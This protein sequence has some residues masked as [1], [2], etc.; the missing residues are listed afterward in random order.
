M[1]RYNV[2]TKHEG[3]VLVFNTYTLSLMELDELYYE[4]FIS[5]NNDFLNDI[6]KP[7]F[8]DLIE[9]GF[10]IKDDV[11]EISLLRNSYWDNK[12]NNPVLH[13][14]VMTTLD[15]NFRCIYC[16][17]NRQSVEM[18]DN[19]QKSVINFIKNELSSRQYQ[20]VHI[21]WYGGEP[22][23]NMVCI[24]RISSEIIAECK[25]KNILYESS[26]M[27]NGYL[28]SLENCLK[29]KDLHVS[30][31]QITIDGTKEIHDSRRPLE[32]NKGTFDEIIKNIKLMKDYV[33]P[34]IRI[35]VDKT[36][37]QS[38]DELLLFFR[39]NGM[40][41]LDIT[42]KGVVSSDAN[43]VEVTM[44]DEKEISNL[45]IQKIIKAKELGLK[46]SVLTAFEES[47]SHFC[48]VDLDSQFIIS[49]NG[50][51]FK[52]GEAYDESDPGFIGTIDEEGHVDIDL[53]KRLLW[54]KDPFVDE[55]CLKCNVLPLCMGGCQLKREVKKNGWCSP[56]LKN[57]LEE[58][59]GLYYDE[60]VEN[61]RLNEESEV[62]V[63]G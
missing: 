40:D 48:I 43:P 41:D 50:S 16:F 30:H 4:D 26:I 32:S 29:L 51:V 42:I 38:I 15:C 10:I 18:T 35:N 60:N 53:E 23:L 19:V 3:K 5:K 34:F 45:I 37:V 2:V 58:L 46:T 7:M 17:E 24:E 14:S 59:I 47:D 62:T 57:N 21:D 49:P 9:N 33:N 52:C 56:V 63:H 8:E 44:I 31:A 39:N 12:V 54:D 11:D 20:A 61:G 1:S 13:I 25:C 28:L 27:T 36:N 6:D 22:L 55:E